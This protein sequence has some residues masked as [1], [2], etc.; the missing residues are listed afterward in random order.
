MKK[1]DCLKELNSNELLVISGGSWFGDLVDR[2]FS[3]LTGKEDEDKN[4]GTGCLGVGD[5]Y[6]NL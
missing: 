1:L 2:V 6:P 3:M 5:P 4:K